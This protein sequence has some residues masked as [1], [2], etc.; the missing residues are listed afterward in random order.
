M[1]P[2]LHKSPVNTGCPWDV[3]L[4]LH[5]MFLEVGMKNPPPVFI[6]RELGFRALSFPQALASTGAQFM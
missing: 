5:I 6:R 3:L 4:L 1:M 2:A